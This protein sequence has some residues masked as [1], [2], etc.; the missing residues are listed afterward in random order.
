MNKPF[1]EALQA[2]LLAV[3]EAHD[4]NVSVGVLRSIGCAL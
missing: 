1:A 3:I 4:L 2:D